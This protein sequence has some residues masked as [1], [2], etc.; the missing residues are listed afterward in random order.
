VLLLN[1]RA[2]PALSD[3]VTLNEVLGYLGL[4]CSTVL[5]LRVIAGVVRDGVT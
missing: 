3:T 1:V 4:A 2:G 5:V